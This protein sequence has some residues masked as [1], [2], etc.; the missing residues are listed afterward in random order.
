MKLKTDAGSLFQPLPSPR[1]ELTAA[2]LATLRKASEILGRIV[3]LT[4]ADDPDAEG[5]VAESSCLASGYIGQLLDLVDGRP[6][7]YPI[8]LSLSL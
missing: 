5:Y 3:A 4:E 1:I 7:W 2:E 6:R 8:A